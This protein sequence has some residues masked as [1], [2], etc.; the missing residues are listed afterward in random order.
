MRVLICVHN[1]SNGGAERVAVLWANGFARRGYDVHVVTA[2]KDAPVDYELATGVTNHLIYSEGNP[3]KRYFAKVWQLRN[4]LKEI[5]PDVAISVLPPFNLWLLITT[6]GLGVPVINTEHDSFE[7]PQSAPMPLRAKFNKFFLNNFFRGVTLLTSADKE[8][9][10]RNKK[11][12]FVHPNPLVFNPIDF[13]PKRKKVILAAGRLN[14]WF[15]KGF[16]L[17]IAAWGKIATQFPDWDLCI[18]GNGE[19]TDIEKLESFITEANLNGRVKLLGFHQDIIRLYQ[20]SEIFVLS[21]R[22]EGFGLV[23]IEAMS[24]GCACIACDYKGRQKEILKDETM[25]LYCPTEDIDAL[26]SCLRKMI[27]NDALR[28]SIRKNSV[29]RSKCYSVENIVNRWEEIF[30]SLQIMS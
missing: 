21:S 3:L 29:E 7:R 5:K 24:Q 15:S 27:E 14:D 11:N 10:G 25:G 13:E 2:E 18:A 22:Y 17:L 8:I 20:E 19:Q 23:L 16:D 9:Y 28:I 26:S 6:I 1:L 12:V 30:R 4:L